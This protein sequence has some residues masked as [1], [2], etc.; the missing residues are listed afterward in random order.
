MI[1]GI[2]RC[3]RNSPTVAETAL[4]SA[5]RNTPS[6]TVIAARRPKIES[7][8]KTM[9]P[10][11]PTMPEAKRHDAGGLRSQSRSQLDLQGLRRPDEQL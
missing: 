6:K 1:A 3:W 8:G 5:R 2:I 11:G 9:K 7:V 4:A 10:H